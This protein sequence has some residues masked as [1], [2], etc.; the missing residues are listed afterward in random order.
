M[1]RQT[2]TV[3]MGQQIHR[4]VRELTGRQD[5]Y[6]ELKD[7]F[8]E[9]ALSL[10]PE[11]RQLVAESDNQL[12]TAVRLAIAGNI[13]DF[14]VNAAVEDSHLHESIE[15]ALKVPLLGSIEKFAAAL[16]AADSILY[17]ADNTGEIVFDRLLVEQLENVTVAVRGGP[18]INDAT[19]VDAEFAGLTDIVRVIDNGNDAPGTILA[20]CS[21]E[22]QH[23]FERAS[24]VIAKGQG[25]YESLIDSDKNIAFLL[26]AKCSVIAHNVGCDLG[27]FILRMR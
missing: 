18:V 7:R 21:D 16:D 25:N 15:F 2:S 5:P 8:N 20:D 4:L 12:E 14:G 9:L 10:M 23:E 26:R 1:D 6:R 19:M 17:L 27:S 22:F 24:L 13:I 11:M 3:A